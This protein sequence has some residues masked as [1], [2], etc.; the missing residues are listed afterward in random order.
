MKKLILASI[1][2]ATSLLSGCQTLKA[3]YYDIPIANNPKTVSDVKSTYDYDNF[4]NE[5]WMNTEF[6]LTDFHG[7]VNNGIA[8]SYRA[9]Y[10]NEDRTKPEFV[11]VLFNLKFL[12]W[13]FIDSVYNENGVKYDFV[14]IDRKTVTGGNIS[15]TFAIN[16][17]NEQFKE[18]QDND[19]T[20]KMIGKSKSETFTL[21]KIVAQSF[22]K[23]LL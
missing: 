14:Q 10:K 13:Y 5:G 22:N 11:Q 16:L 23:A 17:T 4:Q 1:I 7:Y 18:L 6:Y 20:L 21:P 3:A 15:E 2:A 9:Y 19:L 8:Y 12:G